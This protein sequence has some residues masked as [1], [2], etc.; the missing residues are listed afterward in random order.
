MTPM[1]RVL[2]ALK[3]LNNQFPQ[4]SKPSDK[5]TYNEGAAFVVNELLQ[6][7]E[8]EVENEKQLIVDTCIWGNIEAPNHNDAL[9]YY[10]NLS[11]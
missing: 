9:G 6:Q 5:P 8:V 11:K 3:Q 10:S 2:E 7:V 1:Q 4:P